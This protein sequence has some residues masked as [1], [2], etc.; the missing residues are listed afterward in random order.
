MLDFTTFNLPKCNIS[1]KKTFFNLE[2]N[3]SYLLFIFNYCD[4][5]HQHP[6][7]FLNTKFRP[8]IKIPKFGT[9][10]VLTGYFGLEFQ[11]TNVVFKMSIFKF[12]NIQRF[13]QK[14]TWDQKYL[15]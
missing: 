4:I 14:Q 8:K 15:I 9:K 5:L 11:K 1:W 7:T 10:I 13:I 6:Q 12:F 2:P 3:L